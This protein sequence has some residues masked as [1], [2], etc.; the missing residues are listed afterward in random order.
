MT[1]HHQ[2]VLVLED[3]KTFHGRAFGDASQEPQFSVGEVVFNTAMSGYQEILTDPSYTDQIITFTYPQIGNVGVNSEDVESD[4]IYAKALIIRQLPKRTSNWRAHQSLA[5]Y[6]KQNNLLGI[7][8]ID[9]RALTRH[10]REKGAMNG[11]IVSAKSVTPD[12][13]EQALNKAKSFESLDGKNL[14]KVVS[15][16]QAQPW[17]KALQVGSLWQHPSS[18][19]KGPILEQSFK[20]LVWDFG[21]KHSILRILHDL[22]C[23]LTLVPYDT[24]VSELL[25][26]QADG[27]FLSNGPGD[28]K[29]CTDVIE[30]LQQL[31]QLDRPMPMFGICLGYQLLALALGAKTTKMAFGHHGGNHPVQCHVTQ[32]VYITSQNHGFCVDESTLPKDIIVTYRSLFDNT[33][34][35]FKH[36][37][38]PIYGFQGHPEAGPGPND[39]K[40]LFHP[41]ISVMHHMQQAKRSTLQNTVAD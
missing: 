16:Q 9:T 19:V 34:Q 40:V 1:S 33:L 25:S 30:K 5:D 41:F 4:K 22:G 15:T 17:P 3:G 13:L 6:C 21:V 2:A 7:S 29:A 26:Y 27:L 24:P 28:P 12:L 39:A 18:S 11:C 14:A 10:L 31:V 20:V 23:E 8:D 35:G 38:L 32:K 36:Q 37:S